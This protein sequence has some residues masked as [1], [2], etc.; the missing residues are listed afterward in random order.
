MSPAAVFLWLNVFPAGALAG[1]A[2]A[3]GTYWLAHPRPTRRCMGVMAEGWRLYAFLVGV[4]G[5]YLGAVAFLWLRFEWRAPV[6]FSGLPTAVGL[7]LLALAPVPVVVAICNGRSG[8]AIWG[9][10]AALVLGGALVLVLSAQ[11]RQSAWRSLASRAA[12]EPDA[13]HSVARL[14]G[15][16]MAPAD[17]T[18]AVVDASRPDAAGL[19][20]LVAAQEA[21]D[22]ELDVTLRTHVADRLQAHLEAGAGGDPAV[23]A[24]WSLT[25]DRERLVAAYAAAHPEARLSH[26]EDLETLEAAA[27]NAVPAGGAVLAD[28]LLA[29]DGVVGRQP[30]QPATEEAVAALL[31]ADAAPGDAD[32]VSWLALRVLF[33]NGSRESMRAVMPAFA[34]PDGPAWALLYTDCPRS[35]REL[36]ALAEEGGGPVSDGAAA[37]LS[38]VRRYCVTSAPVGG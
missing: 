29:L 31:R 19:L 11:M 3:W 20:A 36:A 1:L 27:V 22:T 10:P 30:L 32:P 14:E 7:L 5:F 26:P 28:L 38:W 6:A 9:R 18:R 16:R 25:G 34:A 35:T 23:H 4:V 24:I 13:L 33:R 17:E 8:W 37:V 12:T 21:G 15:L 2:A